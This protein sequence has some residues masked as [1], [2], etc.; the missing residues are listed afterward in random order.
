MQEKDFSKAYII[1]VVLID[2]ITIITAMIV[3]GFP[4]ALYS[5]LLIPVHVLTLVW[6]IHID[7][8]LQLQIRFYRIFVKN[9]SPDAK[10]TEFSII[11]HKIGILILHNLHYV[12]I[13][14]YTFSNYLSA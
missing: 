12:I 4:Y 11:Y 8:A 2:L 7:K 3:A 10:P 5:L 14:I 6:R 1:T 9:M 13:L